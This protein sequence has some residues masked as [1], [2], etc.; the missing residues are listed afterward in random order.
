MSMR[1][2]FFNSLSNHVSILHPND[3]VTGARNERPM[4]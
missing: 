4:Y 2:F 3:V 1:P